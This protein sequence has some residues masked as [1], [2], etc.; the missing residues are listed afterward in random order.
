MDRPLSIA[1]IMQRGNDLR[2]ACDRITIAIG[3]RRPPQ[4]RVATRD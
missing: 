2:N 3:G 4:R 1:E